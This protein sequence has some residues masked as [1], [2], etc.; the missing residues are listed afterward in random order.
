MVI[1]CDL[2]G[3]EIEGEPVV[4]EIEGA[5]LNLCQRCAA[6]YVNVKGVRVISGSVRQ[7]VEVRQ[8]RPVKAPSTPIQVKKPQ[9]ADVSVRQAERLELIENFGEAIREARTR[10]GISRDVL[11]SMLGIKES[12][13]RNI[14]EGRLMPDINLARKIEK[15]LGIRLLVEAE[16]ADVDYVQGGSR[17]LTLGDVVEVRRGREKHG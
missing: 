14:E 10:L 5:V 2:C 3:R 4:V 13:L 17:E 11:A 12:T 15:V 6:R 8:V 9:R 1:T 16:E 7:A